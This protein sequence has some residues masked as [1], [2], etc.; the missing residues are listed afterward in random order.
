[1]QLAKAA[2]AAGIATLL[3]HASITEDKVES[4]ILAGGFG[5]FMDHISAA[6]IG[7]FPKSFLSKTK[8]L[9]NTAGEGAVLALCSESARQTLTDIR[10]R[11]EYIELST[12]KEFNE[13]FIEHILFPS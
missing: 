3:H 12:S 10:R 6:K 1:L 8:T 7:L 5:S 4:F 11:C 9:G 2:I 13:Q